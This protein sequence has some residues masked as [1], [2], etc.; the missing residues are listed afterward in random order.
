MLAKNNV[1][2]LFDQ[3]YYHFRIG[4]VIWCGSFFTIRI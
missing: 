3:E 4:D 1:E 2:V